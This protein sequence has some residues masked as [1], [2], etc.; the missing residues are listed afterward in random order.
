[1][2]KEYILRKSKEL[3]CE[4]YGEGAEFREG[5]YEAIEAT[6]LNKKTLVVQKTGWGKSLVYFICTKILRENNYGVAFVISPLLT[7]MENQLDAAV[8]MGLK[9]NMLNSKT[10]EFH[11]EIIS[12]IKSNLIDLVFITPETLFNSKVQKS[13]KDINIGLF[14]IDE[15]HCISDWGHDFRLQY[16]NIYKVLSIM[17]KNIPI[18]ATTATA[19]NRVIGDLKKQLGED[20]Y[21]STGSLMR[22]SLYIQL[23]NLN[24]TEERYGWILDNINKL[25][26]SGIIYC[27]TQR[28]CDYLTKFLVE[29]GISAKS[30]YSRS[31]SE[32]YIN[33]IAEKEFLNNEI[34]VIV[35][36]IKLGMGYDKGDV[37]FVVH[38]QMPS[39]LI[40][41]YQQIGRAGRNIKNADTILMI[42]NEDENIQNYFIDTAFPSEGEFKKILSYIFESGEN[43]VRISDILSQ[44]NIRKSRIEKI[45]TFLINDGYITKEN[46]KYYPTIKEYIYDYEKYDAIT[47]LRKEEQKK[48]KELVTLKS[49]YNRFIVNNLDDNTELNCNNCRNCLGYEKFPSV[50]SNE[51]LEKAQEYLD[52]LLIPILPR[53]MWV[54]TKYTGNNKISFVNEEG[55]ALCKYNDPGFGTLV[56][57]DK[58]EKQIFCDELEGKSVSVLKDFIKE[59]EITGITFVPSLRSDIVKDF[60]KRLS[61][62]LNLT[63]IDALEKNPADKQK[64]MENTSY[65][66]ENAIKSFKIKHNTN[67]CG[68]I[69]LVDDVV[70]SKWTITVCGS[71]LMKNG[72]NKVYPFALSDSSVSN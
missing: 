26:G 6:I 28:T 45:L 56:K 2:N 35:A 30:Y 64:C 62:R 52:K 48:M 34:K 10:S 41:Y 44:N 22:Y 31:D 60:A 16:T 55:I 72:A 67:L 36:T 18:L 14:V 23:L 37:G 17:P 43:G 25:N 69:L 20:L 1:M 54:K 58:Y 5:Q 49:C 63:F 9:C 32:E 15:A 8:N 3:L 33:E 61:D 4:I 21:V 59:K 70:D 19:N 7:L 46:S 11:D 53:K 66:C 42:G 39:N 68:N 29:N 57:K 27:L 13:L 24:T 51:N 65:Q 12:Q 38:F 50:V 47:K 71:F 40:S